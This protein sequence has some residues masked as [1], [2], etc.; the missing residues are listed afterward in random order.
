MLLSEQKV[1]GYGS[2]EIPEADEGEDYARST[3]RAREVES[4]WWIMFLRVVPAGSYEL[5]VERLINGAV[6]W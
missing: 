2:V 4:P 5:F 6:V 1:P 3:K